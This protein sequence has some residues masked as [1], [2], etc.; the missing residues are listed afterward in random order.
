MDAVRENE[1][2]HFNPEKPGVMDATFDQIH[3]PNVEKS[4][5]SSS[6]VNDFASAGDFKKME[7]PDGKAPT[8]ESVT[9]S[10]RPSQNTNEGTGITYESLKNIGDSLKEYAKNHV[11]SG[12]SSKI[13]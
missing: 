11:S 9:G 13:K 10:P 4:V 6:N 8:W 5:L 3:K 2:V 1:G 12:I 7:Y